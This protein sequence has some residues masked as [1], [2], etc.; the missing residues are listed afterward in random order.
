MTIYL[1]KIFRIWI[2]CN[3]YQRE[4]CSL[5][6]IANEFNYEGKGRNGKI[7]DMWLGVIGIPERKIEIISKITGISQEEILMNQINKNESEILSDWRSFTEILKNKQMDLSKFKNLINEE[8]FR[9][10]LK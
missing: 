9:K 4:N 8:R 2:F 10:L 3:L 6:Q 7:R 5:S 1:E